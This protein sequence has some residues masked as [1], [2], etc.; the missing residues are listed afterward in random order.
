MT[1]SDGR[2][3][4]SRIKPCLGRGN[5]HRTATP[6]GDLTAK[7]GDFYGLAKTAPCLAYAEKDCLRVSNT[8]I[9]WEIGLFPCLEP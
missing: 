3:F 9:P 1:G 7:Y 6:G 8:K 5:S 2:L 4:D